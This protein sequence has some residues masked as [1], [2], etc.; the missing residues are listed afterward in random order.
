MESLFVGLLL[1]TWLAYNCQ[2]YVRMSRRLPGVDKKV[3]ITT[4]VALVTFGLL[5]VVSG[6]V[7]MA[8][9]WGGPVKEDYA[10]LVV[11]GTAWAA[12]GA[13]YIVMDFLLLRWVGSKA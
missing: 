1:L 4:G 12:V 6:A 7:L 8:W 5:Y 11:F 3:L 2:F 10:F 13:V 9:T